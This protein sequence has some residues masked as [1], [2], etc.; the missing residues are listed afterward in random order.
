MTTRILSRLKCGPMI[1]YKCIV[2]K[3][4]LV[5]L[6]ML[7]PSEHFLNLVLAVAVTEKDQEVRSRENIKQHA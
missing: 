1:N 3:L 6:K 4:K 7:L 2:R 5:F